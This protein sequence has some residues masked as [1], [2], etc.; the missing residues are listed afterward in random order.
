MTAITDQLSQALQRLARNFDLLLAGKPVR[1][2]SETQAEV[3][4]ALAAYD[5]AL[6]AAPEADTILRELVE[7][8]RKIGQ[9]G[10]VGRE[11]S[12]QHDAAWAAAFAWADAQKAPQPRSAEPAARNACPSHCCPRHGCKYGH[13]DCPVVTGKAQP[14]YPNNNGCECCEREPAHA[15]ADEPPPLPKTNYVLGRESDGYSPARMLSE[16]AYTDDHMRAYA[17]A[18]AEWKLQAEKG[19]P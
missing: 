7:L 10:G 13:D 15:P 2:V 8:H 6:S 14:T 1:D 4:A 16:P 9:P 12:A 18:Y 3:T 17:Q 11:F 19:K 5:A